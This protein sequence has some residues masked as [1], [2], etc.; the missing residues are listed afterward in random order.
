MLA[1]AGLLHFLWIAMK[2]DQLTPRKRGSSRE[3]CS[4]QA[5]LLGSVSFAAVAWYLIKRSGNVQ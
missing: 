1:V 5:S 2:Y 4:L 3:S